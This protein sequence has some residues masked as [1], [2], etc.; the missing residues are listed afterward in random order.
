[1]V[2][3]WEFLEHIPE[4]RL[5]TV[6]ENVRRHLHPTEGLFIAS[7]HLRPCSVEGIEYHATVRPEWWWR[8]L[9]LDHGFYPLDRALDYFGDDWVRGPSVEQNALGSFHI[10]MTLSPGGPIVRRIDRLA[11]QDF[12]H[13]HLGQVEMKQML[14]ELQGKFER[15]VNQEKK[16]R[17]DL[18]ETRERHGKALRREEEIR[19]ALIETRE[20]HGKALRRE[21]EIRQALD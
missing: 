20:R 12:S 11:S 10:V 13:A 18:I 7:I 19:Q 16:I 9:F 1:M 2:T 21:E 3:A 17:Q 5:P 14:L 8:S 15:S 4:E 6:V